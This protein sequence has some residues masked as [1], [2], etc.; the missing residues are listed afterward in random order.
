[1]VYQKGRSIV[2][3]DM[4]T[5]FVSCERLV[6]SRL[7]NI[8]LIIGGY[9]SRAVVASCS[10]EA[11]AYGVRSGMPMR[12]ALRMCPGAKV[13]KGDFEHYS[14]CSRLVTEIL[15]EEAPVL[16]K[17]SI[18]E[19]YIDVSGLDR[20]FGCLKW[21]RKLAQKVI[22]ESGLPLS[23]GLSVNKTVAKMA[24][25]E[26]KPLGHMQVPFGA[27]RSFLNPLPIRKIPMLGQA[28]FNVLS[29]IG[30]RTIQT[31]AGMP[32]EMM[33]QL[34]GKNGVSLWH[35]ANGRDPSPIVPYIQRKSISNERTFH[36]DTTDVGRLTSEIVNL[37]EGL[38]FQLRAERR[39]CSV[40]TVKIR[41]SNFDTHTRQKRITYTSSDDVL[42]Q[43]AKALFEQV[44]DRRMLIR[45][46]GV[47]LSGLVEGHQQV[48]LFSDSQKQIALCQAMDRIRKRF[49]RGAV[50]RAAALRKA[51]QRPS[52]KSL[53]S[54]VNK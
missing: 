39:L 22:K 15:S 43:T 42:L 40:V 2:H 44:Y 46:V 41:Y 26:G 18:D 13:L 4:D 29:R 50:M 36:R 51:E 31:L 45:L 16:E 49:G 28:S 34:L 14:K 52:K 54:I 9:S 24:T 8:P 35:K 6:D 37:V 23:F 25:G 12:F 10:Y 48:D 3:M 38:A 32:P 27:V 1:M 30:V 53:L 19:F 5:F 21:T 47:K 11:R 20:Y 33:E 7:E 17:A